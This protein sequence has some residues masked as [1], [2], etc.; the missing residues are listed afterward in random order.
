M[1]AIDEAW[2]GREITVAEGEMLQISLPENPT[3]GFRWSLEANGEPACTLI[4]SSFEPSS[5]PPGA[6]GRHSW[7]FAAAR[8]GQARIALAYERPWARGQAPARTFSVT[9]RVTLT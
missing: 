3:T 6:G 5:G 9:V 7:R 1:R 8:P 4:D 2:N